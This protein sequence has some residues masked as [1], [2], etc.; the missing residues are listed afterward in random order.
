MASSHQELIIPLIIDGKEDVGSELFD[1]VSPKTGKVCWRAVSS[2][3]EDATRAVEAAQ[4]SFPSW[5]KTKPQQKQKILFK[6]ADI[7]ESRITEYGGIMETEMGG[8]VGPV[9]FW[10]LPTAVRFLRDIASHIPLITGGLPTVE[11]QGTSALIWKEPY[12]VILGI[13][14]WNAPFALGM[15]AAATAIATGNTTVIKGSELT[16]RC[17]WALGQVFQDAGLPAGVLNVIYCKTSDGATVTNTIIRH[18]AVKKINFT[19][20]TDVGRKIAHTCGENLKPCLME[21]GGKNNAI[22]CADADLQKAAKECIVGAV[23][24]SGQICMSTDRIII[25]ADIAEQFLEILK[26]TIINLA[27]SVSAPPYLVNA[28][29]K[30]RLQGVVSK[31]L[32]EGAS[33]FVGDIEQLHPREGDGATPVIFAPMIIGDIQDEMALWQDENFGPVAAYRIAKSDEE[34]IAIANNTEF[35]LVAAVFTKDLRKGFAIAK[36]LE[37][38]AVHIN[39]MSVRD[40][41]ALP[42]GGV[43]NSGWG[44]FNTM[45]G[46][47][48]FLVAKSV[49]WD[50]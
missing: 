37:A 5:S 29:A 1:V 3:S 49:T 40:E 11:E 8:A 7:L 18:P 17:Y 21:L 32:S 12:G 19:G 45:L 48:E 13:S 38:G 23:L 6:A 36:Q 43:K 16:P 42:M 4:R 33:S 10:V 24:H 9:H 30:S 20:S 27:S 34:A 35:G 46:M 26:A 47:E 14:P 28:A 41:P 25:H 15:R 31:A 44:R 22:V 2:S 39:S 50:D